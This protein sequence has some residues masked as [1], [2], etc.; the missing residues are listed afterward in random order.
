MAVTFS[1]KRFIALGALLSCTFLMA[2]ATQVMHRPDNYMDP[3]RIPA[4]DPNAVVNRIQKRDGPKVSFAYFTNW[5][6][7]GANFRE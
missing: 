7:Y 4:V 6:I 2:D 1:F 3:P 5:G